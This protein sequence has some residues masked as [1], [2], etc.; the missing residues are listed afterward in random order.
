MNR[1]PKMFIDS[2]QF[3][4][5]GINQLAYTGPPFDLIFSVFTF[6]YVPHKIEAVEMIYNQLLA[7]DGEAHI[8]FPGFLVRI[9]DAPQFDPEC[10]NAAFAQFLE[11]PSLRGR[12][13]GLRFR[14]IPHYDYSDEDDFV[15]IGSFGVLS[16][17][18]LDTW[19]DLGLL[20][21][22]C[23]SV[24]YEPDLVYVASKYQQTQALFERTG[25]HKV[26]L[27]RT[28]VTSTAHVANYEFEFKL[29]LCIHWQRSSHIIISFPGAART[30]AGFQGR[31][32]AIAAEIQ[33]RGMSAVVRANNPFVR[34][35][36]YPSMLVKN[37][38]RIIHYCLEHAE[39]ICG[40]S[41]PDL[42]LLGH[43]AGASA[44]GAIASEYPQIKKLLLLAPSLDAGKKAIRKG[45][46]GFTG[47]VHIVVGMDDSVV[48]PVYSKYF[49]HVARDASDKEFVPLWH[50]DHDFTGPRN[51]DLLRKAPLWA[52]FGDPDF[53]DSDDAYDPQEL[54]YR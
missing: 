38:R 43:S 17:K 45:L 51:Y 47:T 7:P 40:T 29:D 34:S 8:H 33:D 11:S 27:R 10:G 18:K 21:N 32:K 15:Q 2:D 52:F 28:V 6:H 23:E 42:Y 53:P 44:A 5:S 25:F 16:M 36:D 49:W 50:C 54:V 13:P 22:D 37:L 26:T 30:V 1:Y 39:E 19:L 46:R 48:L 41:T 31:F 12:A 4:H 9:D 24:S 35:V 14:I 3:I 20:Y